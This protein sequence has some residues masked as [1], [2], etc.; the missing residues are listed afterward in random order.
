M[1]TREVA[2]AANRFGLGAKPGDAQRIGRDARGWLLSQLEPQRDTTRSVERPASAAVLVETRELRLARQIRQQARAN[3]AQQPGTTTPQPAPSVD[4]QA[5][6][7]FG[8]FVR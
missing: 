5:I 7:E 2:I 4:A 3:L 6:R 8:A 1:L